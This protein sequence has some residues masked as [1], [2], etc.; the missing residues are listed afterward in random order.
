MGLAFLLAYI[1]LNFLSPAEIF[2]T[3]APYHV[4]QILA[5]AC[6]IPAVFTRMQS[7]EVG[8]LRTQFALLILFFLFAISSWLP[9]GGLGANIATFNAIAPNVLVYFMGIVF[10]RS[11]NKLSLMRGVLVLVA[12]YIIAVA[13][14]EVP[15][16]SASGESTPYVLSSEEGDV[17][18]QGRGMM[19]DPNYFGQFLLMLIPM[20]FVSKK[21]TGLGVGYAVVIPI[22]MVLLVGIYFTNSRGTQLGVAV[23]IGLYL[24]RRLK[25]AGAILSVFIGAAS[26]Y[27]INTFR[28]RTISISG[29]IDRL[30]IWSDGMQFF[31]HSPLWG[32]GA[33]G[34]QELQESNMTAHNSFLLCAAE[35]GMIG[36]FL[37]MSM[38][39][40]T[41]IQLN[42]I[43][44]V[45][46][47]SNPILGRW[48]V[49]MQFALGVY[50]FTSFF[51]SRTYDLPLFLLLGMSGG[52]IIAAGGDKAIP[53]QG[54]KW[55]IKSLGLCAGIL[56][57]IYVMLRLRLV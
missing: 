10:L 19:N 45:V 23:L 30:A 53:L 29:G 22:V 57:T 47:K 50:M 6:L 48:A 17:R 33:R 8:T 32:V 37:W 13:L 24:T 27:A 28:G 9:H 34:F 15:R 42:R 56:M 49:A 55:Q 16:A 12:I 14:S 41:M 38:I 11:P 51:I 35:L 18:I 40:V 52:V 21:R 46:E 7:P 31:K 20:V 25:K 39:V 3:L 54:T 2:P 43:P 4:M 44:K 1:A 5:V 26:L 36:F